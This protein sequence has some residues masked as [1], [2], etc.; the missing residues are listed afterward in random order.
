MFHPIITQVYSV[1]NL[2][3]I[4]VSGVSASSKAIGVL[5][6]ALAEEG[7]SIDMLNMSPPIGDKINVSFTVMDDDLANTLGTLGK[8]QNEHGALQSHVNT[9]NSKILLRGEKMHQ[10]RGVGAAAFRCLGEEGIEVKMITS[11]D[12]DI[13]LLVNLKDAQRAVELLLK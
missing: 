11:S 4:T 10:N 13:T 2:S 1:D 8:L 7:V 6:G 12:V 9:G 5:L 3:L